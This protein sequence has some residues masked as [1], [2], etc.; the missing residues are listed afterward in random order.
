M[1][2]EHQEES[3]V[4]SFESFLYQMIAKYDVKKNQDDKNKDP[5]AEAVDAPKVS[6]GN[7]HGPNA[8]ET[9][10]RDTASQKPQPLKAQDNDHD[11]AG[12]EKKLQ[13]KKRKRMNMR[14]EYEEK[15]QQEM[16]SSEGSRD[17][18]EVLLRPGRPVTLDKVL[19]FTKTAR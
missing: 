9:V 2:E 12:R 7:R 11:N 4:A 10:Y 14:R 5:A 13:D 8:P 18:G 6:G 16:E 1:V 3:S 15:V 19:S 17:R